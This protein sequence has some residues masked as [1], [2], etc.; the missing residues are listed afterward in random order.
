[1]KNEQQH[2][3]EWYAARVGKVT[4]SAVIKITKR[5]KA[6]KKTAD[7]DKYMRDLLG[8]RLTGEPKDFFQN[9]YMKWGND[10]EPQA[11]AIYEMRTGNAVEDAPFVDHPYI[12]K[13]GA[14]PDGFAGLD[15]LVE[16]KCPETSTMIEYIE[17]FDA[18]GS[19]KEDYLVQMQW[20][21]A[22][23]G[24]AWCDYEVFDPRIKDPDLRAFIRRIPRD[25]AM[26]AEIEA[27]VVQ[28]QT[29]INE[30]E[31]KVRRVMGEDA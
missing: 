10:V 18:D 11:R 3:D 16:I 27:Q 20:Q 25:P 31:A 22:C 13:A 4:A 19:I 15:G 26:I 6:G 1:M 21:M 23:T 29:E 2:S 30:L 7:Y 9:K 28:F 14:S 8:E 12:D 17:M 5:T 24:R